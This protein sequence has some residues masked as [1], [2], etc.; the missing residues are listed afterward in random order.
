MEETFAMKRENYLNAAEVTEKLDNLIKQPVYSI[1]PEAL[2][3]YEAEYFDKKCQKSKE[4]VD[5]AGAIIPGAVQHNLAFNH[6]FPIAFDKA[7]GAFLYDVDG[8][9]Y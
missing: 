9:K 8:S 1:K 7:E 5:M 4:M 6:P 3:E 2:K